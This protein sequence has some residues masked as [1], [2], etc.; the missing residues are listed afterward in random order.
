M[1]WGRLEFKLMRK[2]FDLRLRL[3]FP[4]SNPWKTQSTKLI[5]GMAAGW[6]VFTVLVLCFFSAHVD[7]KPQVDE[8]FFFSSDDPQ[9]QADKK[10]T[11]R[12][13]QPPQIILGVRGA[14]QSAAYY[15][16]IRK[17]SEDLLG[18]EEVFVVQSLSHGP[19]SFDDAVKSPLWKRIVIS[20]DG[21]VTF[22]SVFIKD[23]PAELFLPKIEKIREKYNTDNFDIMIS[24]APFI[25]EMIRRNLMKDL[26]LFSAA[27]F[28][29]F[30]L[31]MLLIFRSWRILIGTLITSANASAL[32]LIA[33]KALNIVIG[34][35][36]ANLSTIVFVMTLSHIVFITFNMK[37]L[38]AQGKVSAKENAT[39]VAIKHTLR[40]S[41]WSMLTTLLG[42]A[43]L[44]FVQATPLRQFGISGSLGT[45]VAFA[46]AYLIYPS[47]LLLHE[48]I[49]SQK[50]VKPFLKNNFGKVII[51][52]QP[53]VVPLFIILTV[54][55]FFGLKKINTDPD[56][57]SYF[58]KGSELRTGLEYIDRNGGSSPL[59]IVLRDSGANKF[60]TSESAA[61]LPKLHMALEL[62]P[63]VGSAVS[64]PLVLAEARRQP[65]ANLLSTDLLIRILETPAFGEISQYFITKDRSETLFVLRMKEA[66]RTKSR[67]QIIDEIESIIK[68]ERLE[69]GLIGGPYLLQGSMAQL[70]SS[71]LISGLFLLLT[72]FFLM[73]WWITHSFIIAL[74]L[75]TALGMIP[76]C[77]LGLT[78]YFHI[79]LDIISAPAPNLAIAMG[80]DAMIHML[81][82]VRRLG[83]SIRSREVWNSAIK[84]L[85][86]PVI[87]SMLIVCS[88]FGIFSLSTF[89]PTQRF[90]LSV[91][92]GS[93]L[94]PLIT[95]FVLPR[96]ASVKTKPKRYKE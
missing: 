47:F 72:L 66:G 93:F 1:S 34:P 19:H 81:I 3:T 7:L 90:G 76:I 57:F 55:C 53:W 56:L 80:V 70:L 35:L 18:L 88:G 52:L 96:F 64:L 8:N 77:L 62:H 15:E 41:F 79:P 39:A 48:K 71:S 74:I 58:K 49:K 16:K 83:G 10:I 32:T 91:V 40:A 6:V 63:A 31:V 28:S 84:A 26:K 50:S 95:L 54:G 9:F 2:F 20:D 25:M 85:W 61:K 13:P 78:G 67:M 30:G 4:L 82:H 12:F 43:S 42:F 27:A 59:K 69:P 68:N 23:V 21:K 60:N 11:D 45:L 38:I 92:I 44:N 65:F 36:T 22:L 33:A 75:L 46:C 24:G 94:A 73:G 51:T 89:P 87:S 5:A 86:K 37:E 17:L 14:I 29:I